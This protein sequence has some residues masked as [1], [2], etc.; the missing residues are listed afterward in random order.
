MSSDND[1]NDNK[2]GSSWE[3]TLQQADP[4]SAVHDKDMSDRLLS[5]NEIDALLG[6]ENPEIA[7][8]KSIGIDAILGNRTVAYER[9]PMLEVV[10][11]R[12]IRQLTTTLRN[13]TS[14]N[15]EISIKEFT[16]VR[17]GDFLNSI[18]LPALLSVVKA[19]EWNNFCLFAVS[20]TLIYSVVDVLLGGRKVE[21]MRR[22][23]GRSYTTIERNLVVRMINLILGDLSVAFNPISKVDFRFERLETNPRFTGIARALDA[24]IVVTLQIDMEDK[25]GHI[26]IALPYSTLEPVRESLLQMFMGE[27]F[28]QDRIW[29]NHLAGALW[30][31]DIQLE[32]ILGETEVTLEEVLSWKPGSQL[33]LKTKPDSQ[34]DVRCGDLDLWKANIGQ[35]SGN[36]SIRIAQSYIQEGE[37]NE[38]H[39]SN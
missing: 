24:A 5:Q 25:G 16:S 6:F 15:V 30:V 1:D 12:L 38:L 33:I 2:K 34:I 26:Q 4:E 29:E 13:F 19:V 8:D 39:N 22:V 18:P 36:I 3:S 31:S 20:S 32:A 21:S 7:E 37:E 27:K 9:L 23:E 11:E 17:F 14:D 28:G 35:R 10:F